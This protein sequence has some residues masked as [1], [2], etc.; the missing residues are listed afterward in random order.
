M[1]TLKTLVSFT[2]TNGSQPRAGLTIDATGDLFGT[3]AS[4]GT[5][6]DGTVFEIAK[7]AQGY[8]T[9]P[10]ILVNFDI[11]NGSLPTA[12]L[13]IDVAG[14]LFGTT[15][16]G[17]SLGGG[18]VGAGTVFELAKSGGSYILNTLVSFAGTNGSHPTS[19]GVIADAAG[20]LFGTTAGG[21]INLGGGTVFKVAKTG[22]GYASAPTAQTPV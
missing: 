5:P 15:Q 1:P 3:T 16:N 18:T 8:A 6:G 20:N 11:T 7:T 13:L 21:P 2:G 12:G 10:T 14:D 22:S 9:T 17:G 19:A 4:G